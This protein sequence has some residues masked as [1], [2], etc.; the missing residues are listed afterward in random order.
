MQSNIVWLARFHQCITRSQLCMLVASTNCLS[1]VCKQ[2]MH[3]SLHKKRLHNE[4]FVL[5]RQLLQLKI[6]THTK[7]GLLPTSVFCKHLPA[8]EKSRGIESCHMYM[9]KPN[10]LQK[11]ENSFLCYKQPGV[12]TQLLVLVH[13]MLMFCLTFQLATGICLQ[14]H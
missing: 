14:S 12:S 10:Q 8:Y 5:S 13:V 7:S 6:C 4:A 3:K 9:V 2:P 1:A 11:A